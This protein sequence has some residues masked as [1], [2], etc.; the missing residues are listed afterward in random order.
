[1][2]DPVEVGV[3]GSINVK[4]PLANVIDGLVVNHECAVGVFQSSVSGQDG[5]IRFHNSGSHL[6]CRINRE[7][8]FRLFAIIH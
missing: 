4:I 7:F 8:Q 3:S 1:V 2:F 5:I 6:G